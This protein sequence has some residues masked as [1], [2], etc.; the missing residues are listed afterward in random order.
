MWEFLQQRPS[1][2]SINVVLFCV[3]GKCKSLGSLKFFLWYAPQPVSWAFS[4]LVS[5]RCTPGVA[6][7]S[8]GLMVGI[9][10]ILS[11]LRV[12]HPGNCKVM[13][14]WLQHP[15]F[16]DVAGNSFFI[17]MCIMSA[18]QLWEGRRPTCYGRGLSGM[19]LRKSRGQQSPWTTLPFI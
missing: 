8:V 6:A 4:S 13:T 2:Q 1:S 7:T 18:V 19:T 11:S 10:S 9:L 15:L 14:W 12:R 3:L 16:T 17:D 5:S